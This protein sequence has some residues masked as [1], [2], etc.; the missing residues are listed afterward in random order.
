MKSAREILFCKKARRFFLPNWL[1]RFTASLCFFS[2]TLTFT[3]EQEADR[4]ISSIDY[5]REVDRYQNE[6]TD[7]EEQYGPY[8]RAL[9]E[10]LGGLANV[11][12]ENG[13]LDRANSILDRQ[14]QLLHISEGPDTFSQ[15]T[16]LQSLI[17]NNLSVNDLEAVT[18]NYENLQFIYSQNPDATVEE[19][20]LAID[21]LR[22]WHHLSFNLDIKPNRINH[23]ITSRRL[24]RQMLRIARDE[25]GENDPLMIPFLYR[26]AIEKYHLSALLLSP[27][28]LGYDAGDRIFEPE[29]TQPETYLRQAYEVVKEIRDIVQQ[30][31]D[32]EADGMAAVY[33][34]DF[35]MLMG[36][37]LAQ[38][39]YREA[40]GLF[41]EAGIDKQQIT[42]FFS[43]PVILP[44]TEFYSTMSD[45]IVAQ[46]AAGY[47]YVRGMDGDDPEVYLGNYTGWNESLLNVALPPAP[48]LLSNFEIELTRAEMRFRISSRGETRNPDAE[49]SIPDTVQAKVDSRDALET[50]V[51]RPRF[52]GNRWRMLRDITMTYWYP[53]EK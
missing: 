26:E 6:I 48:E 46:D 17:K 35:Q 47:R 28:E 40:M 11:Y 29:Q 2:A 34:A 42:D 52:R 16:I 43:R 10:P 3:A 18:D 44:V 36:L 4:L 27:D 30:S 41:E 1:S 15:I 7:L 8:D 45:A 25:Y 32:K 38:R 53:P 14:L 39:S 5:I 21:D 13:I 19:K 50:M 9:L 33:E 24:L 23:F 31:G 51:F 20:L 22:N 12:I 37:G 49:S